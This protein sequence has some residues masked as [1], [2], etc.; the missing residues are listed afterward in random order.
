MTTDLFAFSEQILSSDAIDRPRVRSLQGRLFELLDGLAVVQSFANLVA[1]RHGDG[2]LVVDAPSPMHIEQVLGQLRAWSELPITHLVYTHGHRDHTGGA[3]RIVEDALRRGHDRPIVVAHTAMAARIDRYD[4]T[5]GYNETANRRQF[6][7]VFDLP[8]R[9]PEPPHVPPDL[10]VDD[11]LSL[12]V[13]GLRVE[14]RHGRGE[15]DDHLWAWLPDRGVVLSGDFMI[16]GF[17]NA[18]NPQKV[19]RYA[20][21]WAQ[22]L[23]A[24]I[25]V[26]PEVLIPAHGLPI[27]GGERIARVLGDTATVLESLEEQ[28]L[29]LMNRGATL[30]EVI[31]QVAPPAALMARPYLEAFYDDPEFVVRNIW[32]LYG[33]WWDGNPARL[34]PPRDA[35]LARELVELCGGVDTMAQR[36]RR[37][38]ESGELRLAASL[39]ET[40][41]A[42]APED[43]AAATVRAEV[44]GALVAAEESLMARGIYAAAVRGA[45]G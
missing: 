5:A 33:G 35:Q 34:R 19:Q 15:T 7:E 39:A 8:D 41:W 38:V 9:L 29:D 36:A 27:R 32:R 26:Q 42:A 2:L 43:P 18:G 11:V 1:V 30:D 13:G 23:R 3:S 24:I 12:E 37:H 17:P 14:L 10:V 20:G 16:W 25:A 44:F 21:E 45:T 40:C 22:A 6:A 4:R 31:H 28:T